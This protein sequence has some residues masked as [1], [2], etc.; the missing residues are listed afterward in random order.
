MIPAPPKVFLLV[1][2]S[3]LVIAVVIGAYRNW[4]IYLWR[5]T[6]VLIMVGGGQSEIEVVCGLAH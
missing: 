5:R 6:G 2:G 1:C 4:C 3:C